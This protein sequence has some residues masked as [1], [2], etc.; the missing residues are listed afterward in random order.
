MSFD[1]EEFDIPE[2]Y[3]QPLPDE[4]KFEISSGG[5]SKIM[6][7]LDRLDIYSHIFCHS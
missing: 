7:L 1:L 5:L 3:G 4:I 2:E 6:A